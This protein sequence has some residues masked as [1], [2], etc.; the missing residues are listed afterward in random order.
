MPIYEFACERCRKIFQ[1][2]FRSAASRK[3][4]KCPK[5]GKAGL[6]RRFSSFATGRSR[7]GSGDPAPAGGE[8][9]VDPVRME[10]AMMKLEKEMASLDENDPRQMGR[11]MRRMMEETGQDLGPEVET[12]IRR[13]EAGED[14]EKIE[15]DMGD[16]LDMNS[17]GPGGEYDY[18]DTLY[19]A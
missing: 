16:L 15:E 6:S 14:P 11:F 8:A 4:P 13:L 17:P 12:A 3:K 18:D 2:Y 1:F 7:S 10:R 5:C 9:D 19:E